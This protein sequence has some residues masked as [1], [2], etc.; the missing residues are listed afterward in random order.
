MA[1]FSGLDPRSMTIE[2]LLTTYGEAYY[3]EVEACSEEEEQECIDAME[4]VRIEILTRC[5]Q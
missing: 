3:W 2:E 4:A 1:H 5:G